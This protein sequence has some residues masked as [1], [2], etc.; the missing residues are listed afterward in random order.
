MHHLSGSLVGGSRGHATSVQEGAGAISSGFHKTFFNAIRLLDIAGV[1][2][3]VRY[4][5]RNRVQR[6]S[7]T[8]ALYAAL[9]KK[10]DRCLDYLLHMHGTQSPGRRTMIPELASNSAAARPVKA[11]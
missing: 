10:H 2:R 1:W 5:E 8:P 6:K 7:P 4:G 3:Y 9:V 11:L